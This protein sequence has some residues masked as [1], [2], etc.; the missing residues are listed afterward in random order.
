[1]SKADA[2][3][4]ASIPLPAGQFTSLKMLATAVNGN[5]RGQSFT[6]TYTDGTKSTVAQGLSDWFA[7]ANYPGETTA[8]TMAWRDN[9]TGTTDGETFHLYEY[10]FPLNSAKT[11]SSI[12]LP[13]NRNVVALAI[14]LTGS[15]VSQAAH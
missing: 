8:L 7:P 14:T 15:T 12:S 13:N 5:Q 11:V 1:M 6:V 9:S 4:G 3:T 10:S 2:V